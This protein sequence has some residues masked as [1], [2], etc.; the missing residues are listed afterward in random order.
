M[1]RILLLWSQGLTRHGFNEEIREEGN[2]L[3]IFKA[4]NATFFSVE[5]AILVRKYIQMQDSGGLREA[6]I[7][8]RAMKRAHFS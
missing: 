6:F 3:K 8:F 7:L 1:L 2:D 4:L 5:H